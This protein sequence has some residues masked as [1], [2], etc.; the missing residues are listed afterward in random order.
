MMRLVSSTQRPP[1]SVSANLVADVSGPARVELQ[2]AVARAEGLKVADRL[3]I[4]LDGSPL[5]AEAVPADDDGVVHVLPAVAGRLEVRYDAKVAGTPGQRRVTPWE[6]VELARPSRYVDSDRLLAFAGREVPH[7][8]GATPD[9]VR[10]VGD[11]VADRLSYVGGSSGP[12]DGATD[13][14]LAGQGVCRDYSHLTL[15]LLRALDVPARLVAA[16]APG[17]DPMDF[18]AVVEAAVDGHWWT[19]DATRLAPRQSMVRISTG[20][21]AADTAFLTTRYGSLTLLRSEVVAVVDGELPADD[22]AAPAWVG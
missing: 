3:E 18:H 10:R 19:V 17:C 22:P 13:T 4:L 1:V 7:V 16:Y 15:A 14:L 9:L 2:V 21:D 5:D 12:T 8:G 20:R 6:A 11:W